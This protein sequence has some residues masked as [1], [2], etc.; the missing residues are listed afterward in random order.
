MDNETSRRGFLGAAPAA[1][2]ATFLLVKPEQ[3]RGSQANSSLTVGLIG[4]GRRGTYVSGIFAKNEFA[5]V[6]MLCD[7]YDDQLEAASQKF[8]GAKLFKNYK[9]VLASDVDAVYI[10]TPP[11]LHPEHFEA[12]VAARKHIFMEKPAGVD[13][14]G[15]KRVMAA[16]Q[17]ADKTKRISVDYQQRYGADYN[18]AYD[19]VKSGQLGP[20]RAVRAAWIGGG[21]P[22]RKGHPDSEEKMRNWLFY[23]EFS[24]DI[25]VEQNCHNLDVVNWFLGAHP[26]RAAGY[27]GR[28]QR[29]D[30]GNIMDNLAVTFEYPDGTILSYSA[31]QIMTKNFADV[32]ET[33]MCEN[34]A[35]NTSRKGYSVYDSETRN[36]PPRVVQSDTSKGDITYDAVNQFIE[37]AR[38]GKMENAGNYAAE[39]TLTAILAREAIYKKKEM[40][41]N[42]LMKG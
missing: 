17:K 4:A 31:N 36:E 12:A 9:E 26:V 11:Y 32:S 29:K 5:R 39:S 2:A 10:A 13:V 20:V 7:I 16:A 14:A 34:G 27:G 24:G 21:L 42:D 6:A 1:A 3:V 19:L 40:T 30:I 8:S 37:G 38:T 15:C 22:V 18:A 33:F 35:V 41:W 23:R 28:A 25:I